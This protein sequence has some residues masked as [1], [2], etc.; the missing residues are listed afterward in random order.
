MAERL[1]VFLCKMLSRVGFQGIEFSRNLGMR[2]MSD[3]LYGMNSSLF[4]FREVRI[5][6]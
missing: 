4:H 6:I 1:V 2:M 3:L 5:E